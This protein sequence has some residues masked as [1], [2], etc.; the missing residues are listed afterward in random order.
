M[1]NAQ[2]IQA[3]TI[4]H[5]MGKGMEKGKRNS[6]RDSSGNSLDETATHMSGMAHTTFMM[7][8]LD[9]VDILVDMVTI[10]MD[11]TAITMDMV[12]FVIIGI[13]DF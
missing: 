11:M 1:T 4:M 3:T 12:D 7:T 5:P 8:I 2:N 10:Q 6:I 9:M 13:K